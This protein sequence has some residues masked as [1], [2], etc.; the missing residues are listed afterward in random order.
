M[1][2]G[3]EVV[4]V[5]LGLPEGPFVHGDGRVSFTEQARGRISMWDN[6]SWDV[7]AVTGGG[8]NS[9]VVG[10]DG[11]VY[12]AQNGGAVGAW[13]S[14]DPCT[15]GIWRVNPDGASELVAQEVGG[16]PL[17]APN[18]L[19]F[20]PDG[21]LWLTDP[22]HPFDPVARGTAGRLARLFPGGGETVLDVGSVYCN[23]LAFDAAGLIWVESY[24]RH[25]CRLSADGAREV[26]CQLPAGHVPDGL[27]IASDGRLFIATCGSHG[28]TVLAPD[29]SVL[30]HLWLDERAV[31]TNCA[32]AADGALW[33]T[34]F[35]IDGETVDGAGRLWRVPTDAIGLPVLEG[36]L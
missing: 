24:D 14:S 23:G 5:G 1:S 21:A 31:P 7:L 3:A 19:V 30:D 29:G 15:P 6:G 20:G 28:I 32:F 4:A 10:N 22:A 33:V 36:T 25:V 2:A 9:H 17:A 34:D 27:A 16:T 13:R 18:D 35:G 8:P 11:C 26:V 12:V